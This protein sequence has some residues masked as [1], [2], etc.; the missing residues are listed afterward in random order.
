MSAFQYNFLQ[1]LFICLRHDRNPVLSQVNF[2][3]PTAIFLGPVFLPKWCAPLEVGRL[4]PGG[5]ILTQTDRVRVKILFCMHTFKYGTHSDQS[6]HFEPSIEY[7]R[8]VSFKHGTLALLFIIKYKKKH[9]CYQNQKVVDII[10]SEQ[11]F[12][13]KVQKSCWRLLAMRG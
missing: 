5:T 7:I 4:F 12:Y 9:T 10:S 3:H 1:P 8:K 11:M 2:N 6:R 13:R